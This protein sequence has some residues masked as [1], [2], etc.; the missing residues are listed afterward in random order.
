MANWRLSEE[1]V[2]EDLHAEFQRR[3]SACSWM[4]LVSRRRLKEVGPKKR[5]AIDSYHAAKKGHKTSTSSGK[6]TRRVML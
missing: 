4:S 3:N 5:M 6:K 2:V 1:D